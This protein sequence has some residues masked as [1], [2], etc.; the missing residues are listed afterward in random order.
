MSEIKKEQLVEQEN[1]FKIQADGVRELITLIDQ[2]FN[3][4][5]PLSTE[6]KKGLKLQPVGAEDIK[7]IN[8]ELTKSK[9]L[10]TSTDKLTKTKAESEKL[11]Q[12]IEQ[13]RQKTLQQ[14]NKAKQEEEKTTQQ[15]LKTDQSANKTL[16]E[17]EKLLQQQSK[18]RQQLNKEKEQSKKQSEKEQ[19]RLQQENSL[20][21]QQAK[22][23]NDLRANAKEVAIQFGTNSKQFK[24]VAK[25]VNNLDARLKGV[26][27]SLGQSQR[28]VGNYTSAFQGLPGPIGGAI[29]G[30]KAL[31][32]ASKAFIATPIGAI[33]A[34]IALAL[35]SLTT[36][37]RSSEEGQD[38]LNKVTKVF[39][40]IIGNI[41]DVVAK[42]GKLIFDAF[43]N[44]RE[45][46]L[47]L[48]NTIK[49]N[50]VNRFVGLIELIPNI[51]RAVGKLFKGEFAEAGK[52]AGDA[53]AKVTLGVDNFTEKATT[54]FNNAKN[55]ITELIEETDKEIDIAK[56]LADRQNELN[57]A[58]RKNLIEE[59]KL[60][61][62]I[63]SIRAKA[64]DKENVSA[65]ER[66]N[67]TNKAIDLENEILENAQKIAK[68]KLELTRIEN[69]LSE[70]TREDLEKEAK[71]EQELINLE[72]VNAE[73]RRRFIAERTSAQRE[74]NSILE[75]SEKLLRKTQQTLIKAFKLDD[76]DINVDEIFYELNNEVDDYI[77]KLDDLV[78]R[79]QQAAIDVEFLR[80]DKGLD[81]QIKQIQDEATLRIRTEKLTASE[82]E[83]INLET[84]QKITAL[85][86]TEAEKRKLI[87][88]DRIQFAADS[89]AAL[90]QL[91]ASLRDAELAKAAGDAEKEKEI[92][93]KYANIDFAITAG[94][95]VTDTAASIIRQYAELPFPAAIATSA[96]TGA[97]G[98]AQ[99]IV[100]NTERQKV[101]SLGVGGT[102]DDFGV[103]QGDLHSAASGGENFKDRVKVERGEIASI[104]SREASR[105]RGNDIKE[106]WGAL[107]N[108]RPLDL[109]KL[110]NT[111]IKQNRDS[112]ILNNDYKEL[113]ENILKLIKVTKNKPVPLEISDTH[114]AIYKGDRI[115]IMP[116]TAIGK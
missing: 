78:T 14:L 65:E 4:V 9:E 39:G 33:I 7:K 3:S 79:E 48:G 85:E 101:L 90:G 96:I 23:L 97:V 38:A 31:T 35:K 66:L 18:T 77:N 24:T 8:E 114:V 89:F 111:K 106:V 75:Q 45:T 27:S 63:A 74:L 21:A 68:E 51:G 34:G 67:L 43:N 113:N 19:K 30:L 28:N 37:F 110:T 15:K 29:G 80:S 20:Y 64:A 49:E 55:A 5:K 98:A 61:S 44:P 53:I 59:A 32:Q 107:N 104:Y 109:N 6:L 108:N 84:Q 42:L 36:F 11:L 95:I 82:I 58:E 56:N 100:A 116:K 1:A 86:K 99:L 72:T 112:I 17:S 57:K 81:A 47:K 102:I 115:E 87:I 93:K 76:S 105:N 91:T 26:D 83:K 88:A 54:G 103:I 41:R 50:I 12:K 73:R 60:R 94:R 46:I 16:I 10:I 52:I 13:E 70:S 40:T 71:L 2:L 69:S 22:R 25:E 92:K 62:E